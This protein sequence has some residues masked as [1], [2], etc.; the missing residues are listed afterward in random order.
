V[1]TLLRVVAALW[2]AGCAW[3]ATH[4]SGYP[5]HFGRYSTEFLVL[6][7]GVA[8]VGVALALVSVRTRRVSKPFR[9]QLIRGAA[10]L[11]ALALI[12]LLVTEG[13]I[14]AFDLFGASFYREVTRYILDLEPDATL[15]Y[16]H[17]RGLSAT[18]Q[19]VSVRI[20]DLALR[21]RAI[22]RKDPEEKRILVLGDSV[23][24]GWGVEF[25]DTFGRVAERE[26]ASR[27]NVPLRVINSGV[28]GYNTVQELAFLRR[29]GE[30]L[31]PDTSW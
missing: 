26:L 17:R 23:T 25:D 20:N 12:G 21:E 31:A 11:V 18:Y 1:T 24:F 2:L 5:Q 8:L 28:C 27:L 10:T 16:R 7:I 22:P 14:R 30:K 6:L 29:E 15:V 3:L 9:W 19:G 4:V 13:A